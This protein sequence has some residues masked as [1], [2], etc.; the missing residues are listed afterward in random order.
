MSSSTLAWMDLSAYHLM[1]QLSVDKS[2][3][4]ALLIRPAD[5][6]EPTEKSGKRAQL[7]QQKFQGITD[8]VG[9]RTFRGRVLRGQINVLTGQMIQNPAA[10]KQFLQKMF[11]Q[12]QEIQV[13]LAQMQQIEAIREAAK[14]VKAN[15]TVRPDSLLNI[16]ALNKATPDGLRFDHKEGNLV[17]YLRG[18]TPVWQPV[19]ET[20]TNQ[21]A[22]Q[23]VKDAHN[24]FLEHQRT[25][26]L[27]PLHE[28]VATLQDALDRDNLPY[29][30]DNLGHWEM[31]TLNQ[32]ITD[33]QNDLQALVAQDPE[34]LDDRIT[35]RDTLKERLSALGSV[36]DTGFRERLAQLERDIESGQA[37]G[38]PETEVDNVQQNEPDSH[39]EVSGVKT[40]MDNVQQTGFREIGANLN[41]DAVYEDANGVRSITRGG[42]RLEEAVGMVPTRA[43][44]KVS[45][46]PDRRGLDYR[47][48]DEALDAPATVLSLERKIR[49]LY[50]HTLDADKRND[51]QAM[52]VRHEGQEQSALIRSLDNRNGGA[53]QMLSLR[54]TQ[55]M[56]DQPASVNAQILKLTAGHQLQNVGLP[57]EA[58][59]NTKKLWTDLGL[60]LPEA[61]APAPSAPSNAD[62][63]ESGQSHEGQDDDHSNG[64]RGSDQPD[65]G[66]TGNT[67]TDNGADGTRGGDRDSGVSVGN[68]D[69]GPGG[70]VSDSLGHGGEPGVS[71]PGGDGAQRSDPE[72]G[73]GSA[74]DQPGAPV[75][76]GE[77]SSGSGGSGTGVGAGSE[78][79]G[80]DVGA[81]SNTDTEA[82]DGTGEQTATDRTSGVSGVV[83]GGLSP[84]LAD[85]PAVQGRGERNRSEPAGVSD[86]AGPGPGTAEPTATGATDHPAGSDRG[87]NESLAAEDGA[88]NPPAPDAGLESVVSDP[89]GAGEPADRNG[90]RGGDQPNDWERFAQQQTADIADS[91]ERYV[92]DPK[93][94]SRG[95]VQ[96]LKD[97]INAILRLRQLE[98]AG[99]TPSPE[100]RRE[101]AKYSGFGGIHSKMFSSYSL[102][103]FVRNGLDALSDMMRNE[104]LSA[105]EYNSLRSTILNAHFTHSGIIGPTWEALARMNVPMNRVLEPSSGTLN[106]KSFM[107]ESLVGKVGKFTAVELDPITASIAQAVHPDA[108]VIN[109][110]LEKATFPDQ[111][112]DMAISNIPFG[113]YN[114]FDPEHPSRKHSIHNTFFLKALDKVRPGGVIA[115]VTSSYVL[116]GTGQ[117]VRQQIMDRA[118]VA[119]AYR[120]PTGTFKQSTGTE[121]VTDLVVLQKK[122]NFT[123]N[124]TPLDILSTGKIE[125]PL[126]SGS[127]IIHGNEEYQP[128]EPVPGMKIN[129]VYLAHPENLL[130]DLAVT[131]GPHGAELRLL[132]GGS[133]E[134]QRQTLTKA[135]ESLPKNVPVDKPVTLDAETLRKMQRTENRDHASLD[136]LP[137][138]L[139][140]ENEQLYQQVLQDNG[141][142]RRELALMPKTKA[143]VKRALAATEVMLSVSDLLDAET[144][145]EADDESL[146]LKRA[147]VRD[148]IDGWEKLEQGKA[149][150][151]KKI[152]DLLRGDPR[153]RKVNVLDMVS[154]D[155]IIMRPDIVHGRTVQPITEAP[156][157]AKSIEDALALSL[158]Y[159]GIVSESYMADLLTD[160]EDGLTQE[161]LRKQLVEKGLTFIDPRTDNLVERSVYLSGNLRP[162]IDVVQAIVESDNRFQRNLDALEASLPNPLKPSQIKVALDAFWLPE[163]V[164]NQFIE[165]GLGLQIHGTLGVQAK[166]DEHQRYWRLE[167]S[168]SRGKPSMARISSEQDHVTQS[169]FGTPRRDALEL[170]ANAFTNTI[171]KVQD[172]VSGSQ[173]PRYVINAQETLKA[174]GKYDEIVDAFDRWIFKDPKRAQRL[175]DLYNEKFNT[176][177]LYSPDGSHMVFPGMSDVYVPRKHQVDFAWRAV[178]GKNSMSAHCVGAGKTLELIASAIRG[179]QMGRWSKPMIVVPNH[180]LEQ[181]ANDSH[182]IYPNGKILVMTAADGRASNRAAFVAKCAMGDWDLVICTHSVFEKITVPQE[183]E[184]RIIDMELGKLR[185]ALDNS[186]QQMR[187]KEIEKAIKRLEERLE[188]TMENINNNK[189]N[190]LNMGE[191]GVDFIG[192]DEAHLFKNL[193][194][195]CSQQI[196]GI[197][198]ASSNRA[199]N[200]LIRTQYLNEI[201]GGPYGVMMATGTPI[202][203]S[204]TELYTFTRM[205]RPDLLAEM[206]IANFNDWMGLFGEVKHGMEI[207]PEGG[208]YQM[209]SRLSRF[210]NI[211]ELVKMVRTFIDFKSREDLNLPSP[212]IEHS[213]IVSPQSAFMKG[214]MKYIE[215]RARTVRSKKE[216]G[217]SSAA[218]LIGAEIRKT[219][220]KANDKTVIDE[221]TGDIDPDA[222][223]MPNMDILLT[224][225]TDGRKASLDPRLIHPKFPDDPN[226][227]VN[228][229]VDRLMQRYQQFDNEKAAQMIFCDFSSPTGKGI[230]NIYDD[231]KQK[232]INR[233]IPESEIGFIHHAKTDADKEDLFARVRSG[234]VRFL[235]GSTQK[236]GIGTNVQER[237]VGMEQMDPPWKPAD[238]E[239]RLGRMERQ[240][241]SFDKAYNDTLTAEDSFDLFM[242]ETLNRKLKMITQAMRSPEDCAR[243]IDEETEPG[244]EDILAVTT[245][246]PAIRVFMDA[247]VRLDKLKRMQDS[248][249]DQ[250][251]DLGA[252]I[253]QQQRKVQSIDEY[254]EIKHQEK[255][256]VEANTPLALV[257]DGPVPGLCE[258]PMAVTGGLPNLAHALKTLAGEAK[259]FRTSNIGTLGGLTIKMSRMS[260]EPTLIVERLEGRTD[261]LYKI[262]NSQ[263]DLLE[264]D[265]KRDAFYDA[266]RVLV[267]YAHKIGRDN[268]IDKTT[269]ALESSKSNLRRLEEDLGKPFAY[270]D[271]IK[272][273]RETYQRLS[274]ELGDEIDD[275]K[276]L[277]PEPLAQF[278]EA[279]HEA[280]GEHA[281]LAHFARETADAEKHGKLSELLNDRTQTGLLKLDEDFEDDEYEYLDTKLPDSCNMV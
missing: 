211:P 33:S 27:T 181:F 201:H 271:E 252:R 279:I 123:P 267:R 170:L 129:Q 98:A 21:K 53:L 182:D 145:R 11:P 34:S 55:L 57:A 228:L 67:D 43:D 272:E 262:D 187:P 210:K 130:G 30:L 135:L 119:G 249:I 113:D 40:G 132:G 108:H 48:V 5:L 214:F 124:Y 207:K 126:S 173:P 176:T 236:M 193:M 227:K 200:M 71:E 100:D 222:V 238:V 112:F 106:F 199:M 109:A 89:Q 164:V 159:T 148:L 237:L 28:R 242:W 47:S 128:G 14:D 58:A 161:A 204:V 157:T 232:L 31:D 107:P 203:N 87:R 65:S 79:T 95:P 138:S 167:P 8:K 241:N 83:A 93:L 76:A 122:G 149:P 165:E 56:R 254:L 264:D 54:Y 243:E 92:G 50:E 144:S 166:F 223:E 90:G 102:P 19:P 103:E 183:F 274:E 205:L 150:L 247:R 246:N 44:M 69:R 202:S 10:M 35:L 191:I 184:A 59:E 61:P 32:W 82:T 198:N 216:D 17:A 240:G 110:G 220:Y 280:T 20:V 29:W 233:D 218:E 172:R 84:A 281:G 162:K 80:T 12:G 250:Q 142:V 15:E 261:P 37:G 6:N 131:T 196:P 38:V 139:S 225:A 115:F 277:D 156:T 9:Q 186:E 39:D 179:K 192:I 169:R 41:G 96:R 74:G 26:Q 68:G 111:F 137:G 77:D 275:D 99:D 212:D 104:T 230:F 189:E 217:A 18:H 3:N 263:D 63:V 226:S 208:S 224:I 160:H 152:R 1:A 178:S 239:Q 91:T 163:D 180:M 97:N 158:A 81:T 253:D 245:G 143:L 51:W 244:F 171:P 219:L 266:A 177:V 116:D 134:E 255:A 197:S 276:T 259:A 229:A 88:G 16:E 125:A 127:P 258:G 23:W 60:S 147:V 121:V 140:I 4:Q 234:E 86:G 269:E 2:G 215:A 75:H 85:E 114:V 73:T 101:L 141:E 52:T 195:D 64:E 194:V 120:L 168:A 151:P 175:T 273:V 24:Q 268:G 221:A 36:I 153:S 231:M 46:D 94:E 213:Q 260:S 133:I 190:I 7:L 62:T 136:Q 78:G 49:A 25:D 256:L 66:G 185:G 248:H 174:Q 105:K 209:K 188:R 235:F 206:G 22:E 278:A 72:G 265:K 146:D 257:L 154:E 270:E 42:A 117:S 70:T 45:V 155:G 118:H 251:A 13:T